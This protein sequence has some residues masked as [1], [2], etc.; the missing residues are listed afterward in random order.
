MAQRSNKSLNQFAERLEQFL[1]ACPTDYDFPSG[2]VVRIPLESERQ[3]MAVCQA[4]PPAENVIEMFRQ[5]LSSRDGYSVVIYSVRTAIYAVKGNSRDY[6]ISGLIGLLLD[7]GIVDWRDVLGAL[8]I[9]EECSTRLGIN[10]QSEFDKILPLAS[11]R[12]RKT[13]LNDFYSRSKA[14]RQVTT[15]GFKSDIVDEMLTRTEFP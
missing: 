3:L 15:M 14:Q 1:M 6:L 9:I 4:G 7:D 11:Q 12:R 5:N 13:I 10:L 2:G 8:S